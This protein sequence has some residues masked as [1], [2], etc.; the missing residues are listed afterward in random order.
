MDGRTPVVYLEKYSYA[1][2]FFEI[3][4]VKHFFQPR[5][6]LIYILMQSIHTYAYD[7]N[8]LFRTNNLTTTVTSM[9]L[10]LLLV[11]LCMQIFNLAGICDDNLLGLVRPAQVRIYS[12]LRTP[13]EA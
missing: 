4:I 11:C 1:F 3:S 10:C 8:R 2:A 13:L 7:Q 12:S 6:G 5:L 9:L